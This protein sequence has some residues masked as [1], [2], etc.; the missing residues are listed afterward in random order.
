MKGAEQHQV[1][2][3]IAE[4]GKVE[5]LRGNHQAALENYREAIRM[6]VSSRAPEV[7]FRHYTQCVL[8]S[9]ELTGAY[10]EIIEFCE[11]ATAHYES[12]NLSTKFH[13]SDHGS[14]LERLGLVLLKK[15]NAEAGKAAL[16]KARKTAGEK[17]LPIT[18]EVLSWL[19]RGFH[20]DAA[21]ILS[22][23]R[24]HHYFVVRSDQV[25]TK[26]ASVLPNKQQKGFVNPVSVLGR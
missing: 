4:K 1:H 18:E 24:Q 19:N 14:I 15:G 10:D 17:V 13:K 22:S 21:R 12:L 7:F 16:E 6:A 20:V 5:A 2:L 26:R 8:E 9:L 3:S 23:Q 25:D 11:N